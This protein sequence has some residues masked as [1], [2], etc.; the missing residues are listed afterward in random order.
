MHSADEVEARLQGFEQRGHPVLLDDSTVVR[1]SDHEAACAFLARL[2]RRYSRVT[3]GYV[4]VTARPFADAAFAGPIAQP[5]RCFGKQRLLRVAEEHEIRVGSSSSSSV[6]TS[7]F[8]TSSAPQLPTRGGA[9]CSIAALVRIPGVFGRTLVSQVAREE[10]EA[11][12]R[13]L[14]LQPEVGLSE[15]ALQV[16][17]CRGTGS[18]YEVHVADIRVVGAGIATPLRVQREV[19]LESGAGILFGRAG[20]PIAHLVSDAR[21]HALEFVVDVRRRQIGAQC[22]W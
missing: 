14:Q 4:S 6:L 15:A 21:G 12:C 16:C 7:A 5:E 19:I 3:R 20:N 22:P 10:F 11:E 17:S 2:P 8:R 9:T 18:K 1:H 13:V